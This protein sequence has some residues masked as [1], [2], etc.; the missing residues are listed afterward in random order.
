MADERFTF[1]YWTERAFKILVRRLDAVVN[2]WLCDVAAAAFPRI[3]LG[4]QSRMKNA[5]T[6]DCALQL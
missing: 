4:H 6:E 2:L 3:R 5:D 1:V